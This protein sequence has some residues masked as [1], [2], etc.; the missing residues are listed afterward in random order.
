MQALVVFPSKKRIDLLDIAEP[1]LNGATEVLLRM[2]EVGLCGTDRE[3]SSFEYGSPPPGSDRLILGHE[4]LAE[5]VELGREVRS[6]KSGDL[7]VAMVRRPCP[8]AACRACRAGRPDFC[9]T[10]DYTER[11]IKGADGFL[12]DYVVD[13]EAFLVKVPR[14]LADVAVLVEPLSVVT[15]A[16]YQA[17]QIFAR[18]SYEPGPQRGLVLGAGPIGLLG[19]MVLVADGFETLVYSRDSEESQPAELVRSLGAQYAAS[20][21]NPIESL[22]EGW[23]QFDLVLEAVGFAPL[24]MLATQMLRPN[25]VLALT[26]VPSEASTA[27]VNA[28]RALRNLV[29]R[30][31]AI[32]GTVNA[33]RRDHLS[34]IQ[35]L[36]Q[37]M[38][39][40]PESLRKLITHCVS[41]D[42]VPQIL[43]QKRGIKDVV[44]MSRAA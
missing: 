21:L 12:T 33:G 30:N 8:H 20:T 1:R 2:R 27:E 3:I 35:H 11:G 37:F 24:M 40:F 26:G 16:L 23:G 42:E 14:A 41:L 10:G 28:G 6:L 19:A 36:E 15:K 7:V 22:R 44:Q 4:S 9:V 25:G 31:E 18:L 32:F 43:K 34:A 17:Q 38:V 29:L 13:D 39:L 5:V